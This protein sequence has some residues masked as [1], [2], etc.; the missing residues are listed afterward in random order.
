[1]LNPNAYPDINNLNL[2]WMLHEMKKWGDEYNQFKEWLESLGIDWDKIEAGSNATRFVANTLNMTNAQGIT[3]NAKLQWCLDQLQYTGGV[4]LIDKNIEITTAITVKHLGS[5]V[6]VSPI[7]IFG[8]GKN[9]TITMNGGYFIGVDGQ[10][11]GGLY[12]MNCA[13]IGNSPLTD[14]VITTG[15]NMI[16][17]FFTYCKF[18]NLYSI[19]NDTGTTIETMTFRDCHM[20]NF[21]GD[22]FHFTS[23]L[24]S[25]LIERCYINWCDNAIYFDNNCIN[26]IVRD[27]TIEHAHICGIRTSH[28]VK[29]MTLENLYL[30]DNLVNIDITQNNDINSQNLWINQVFIQMNVGQQGI[31]IP[32]SFTPTTSMRNY[33]YVGVTIENVTSQARD[34]SS[35]T[36]YQ[37]GTAAEGSIYIQTKNIGGYTNV[38]NSLAFY[39]WKYIAITYTCTGNEQVNTPIV[40]KSWSNILSETGRNAISTYYVVPRLAIAG[41]YMYRDSAGG[42]IAVVFPITPVAGVAIQCYFWY[43]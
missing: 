31:Q 17:C 6:E 19:H 16:R 40:L 32:T 18:K 28:F 20:Q 13:F 35:Y 38:G 27:C 39:N 29:G 1:M 42:E 21:G 25:V 22:V 12:F 24:Y 8:I 4:I 37:Q 33:T 34:E 10:Y 43:R 30:E 23:Q 11:T 5:V 9:C 15:S 14:Y 3:D 41:S 7:F 26:V 2:D 36:L